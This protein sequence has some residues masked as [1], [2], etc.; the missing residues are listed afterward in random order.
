VDFHP[1][2]A[3][4]VIRPRA[5]RTTPVGV[6]AVS[7]L[8]SAALA[9]PSADALV[10]KRAGTYSEGKKVALSLDVPDSDSVDNADASRSVQN[11]NKRNGFLIVDNK[12]K[13]SKAAH[14][15]DR[16]YDCDNAV[17]EEGKANSVRWLGNDVVF[18]QGWFCEEFDAKPYLANAKTGKFIGFLKLKRVTPEAQYRFTNL[19]GSLWAATVFEHNGNSNTLVTFDTKNAKIKSTKAFSEDEVAKLPDCK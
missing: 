1:T 17:T 19:Q 12:T 7:L 11:P 5:M 9:G 2:G 8:S 13:K 18:A 16:S 15:K 14:N 4:V 3:T 6:V 10:C